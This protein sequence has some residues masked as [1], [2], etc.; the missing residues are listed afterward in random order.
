MNKREES[1]MKKRTR[2]LLGTIILLV[3]SIAFI[4]GYFFFSDIESTPTRQIS[5]N[6]S[7]QQQRFQGRKIFT[8]T[9]KEGAQNDIVILYLHGG[10]YLAEM[11][12]THWHFISDL[13]NDT[14][15]TIVLPDYPL[16]PKYNYKD[17]FQLIEPIYEEMTKQVNLD[18]F[19]IMGDSAGGGMSL[20][21]CEK[22]AAI[23]EKK[24]NQLILLSPWLDVNMENPQIAEVEKFD[25][26]LNKEAL[27]LAGIA[28][29]GGEENTNYYLISPINGPLQNLPNIT[30]YT[31]TYDILNPDVDVFQ[32]KAEEQN[33]KV[34]VKEYQKQPHIWLLQRGKKKTEESQKAY[35]DLVKQ[36]LQVIS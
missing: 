8:I 22:M 31:G 29:A 14:K 17:V 34:Q 7:I 10:S 28:Y 11:S 33:V 30:I 5:Q 26:D 21:L 36:I 2:V 18:H 20:A 6:C 32:K 19:I 4:V 9:P 12:N 16:T 25:K 24:P 15:A 3:I 1:I 35:E 27:K 23:I 13:V